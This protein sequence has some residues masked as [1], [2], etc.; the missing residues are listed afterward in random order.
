MKC[1]SS[2]LGT[3]VFLALCALLAAQRG[4]PC[5]Q[6]EPRKPAP[7]PPRPQAAASTATGSAAFS[8]G[9]EEAIGREMRD[10]TLRFAGIVLQREEGLPPSSAAMKCDVMSFEKREKLVASASPATLRVLRAAL[11]QEETERRG[12]IKDNLHNPAGIQFIL[13][14]EA[15]RRMLD[16]L[17]SILE[18]K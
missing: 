2:R 5:A 16:K 17:D 15:R 14:R 3:I 13:E 9:E 6:K 1:V 4:C 10:I 12:E 7:A 11:E 18:K 8:A